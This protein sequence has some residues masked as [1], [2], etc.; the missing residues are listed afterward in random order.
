MF[1][2]CLSNMFDNCLSKIGGLKMSKIGRCFSK[3]IGGYSHQTNF[4]HGLLNL[5]PSVAVGGRRWPS[6]S[7]IVW[8]ELG[9]NLLFYL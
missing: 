8:C 3:E 1:D 6:V 7:F 9:L 5:W 4:S 2:N